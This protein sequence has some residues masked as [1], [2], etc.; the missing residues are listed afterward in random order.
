MS[1]IPDEKRIDSGSRDR[2][3]KVWDA[4]TSQETLTPKG[5]TSY[6]DSVAFSPDGR[7]IVS[8]SSY[9]TL[10]VWD[11]SKSAPKPGVE[12]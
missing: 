2:T 3:V 4:E 1:F 10:K 11:A 5:H 12:Q 7:R 6:V 8:G 9:G